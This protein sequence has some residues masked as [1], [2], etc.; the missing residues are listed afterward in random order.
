MPAETARSALPVGETSARQGL[1]AFVARS[2]GAARA[3]ILDAR[4]LT[5]GAIQEN[6]AVDIEIADGPLAGRQ[7]LV[8]RADAATRVPVSLTRAQEFA[9]LRLA[10]AA[11]VTVPEPLWLCTDPA[12]LGRS[13]YLMRRLDGT[14]AGHRIV[15][16]ESL[17]GPREALAERLGRELARIHSV[18][19]ER[20]QDLVPGAPPGAYGF[21][22][23]PQPTPA[24][25][26]VALYRADLDRRAEAYPVLEWALRRLELSAPPAGQI[27]L[28]HQDFR[29]GNYMVDAD[30]LTGILDWEFC[31]WGEPMAD[32]GWFCAKCWRFGAKG[33]EREAGGL[34]PRAA[35]YRG[36]AAESGRRIDP[37]AIGYWEAMAHLRW[38]V[39]ALQQADRYAGEGGGD[40][41]LALTGRL[42]P[43]LEQEL[44]TLTERLEAR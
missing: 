6:W 12:V 18:T 44:L 28:V 37:A 43:E 32:V 29:T 3:D 2:A 39:I 41:Q 26:H 7:A 8:L 16:D 14:A 34:A 5:G 22:R 38:A 33:A 23:R 35:F 21:L 42:L 24:L 1:A 13:F 11:G 9:L 31:A 20:I 17:G 36:Y 15:R 27:V 4:P 30:G 25:D 10:K 19:P 40:L